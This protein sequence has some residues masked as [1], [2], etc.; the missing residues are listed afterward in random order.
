[1]INSAKDCGVNAVKLQTI[2]PDA[3]YAKNTMSYELFKTSALSEK[4]TRVAFEHAKNIG[5]DIFSTVGDIPTAR[6][7]GS[8]GQSSTASGYI[9]G[10]FGAP[11]S[12]NYKNQIEKFSFSS[13]GNATDVGDLTAGRFG[14]AGQQV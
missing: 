10:G 13:D 3:N 4:E 8:T 9:A 2:N 5:I 7:T 14:G 6:G 11:P 12:P 1:M